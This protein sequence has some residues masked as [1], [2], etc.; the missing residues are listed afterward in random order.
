MPQAAANAPRSLIG[1][2]SDIEAVKM[3]F[4]RLGY[5]ADAGPMEFNLEVVRRAWA[6]QHRDTLV[7]YLRADAAALRFI[8]DP[9][10]KA[11][12]TKILSDLSK[13]PDDVVNQMV[14]TINDPKLDPLTQNA[15]LDVKG[16]QHVLDL[17]KEFG[18]TR[19]ATAAGGAFSS[20]RA[21]P[22]KLG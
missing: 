12:V 7:R 9:K 8:H 1:E 13:E 21:M 17:I 11:E 14:A 4:R 6:E 2:P 15:E 10:N 19:Q 20:I 18:L 3:G 5:T 22:G 16:F